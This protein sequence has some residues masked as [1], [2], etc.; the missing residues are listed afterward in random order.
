MLKSLKT[1]RCREKNCFCPFVAL[2]YVKMRSKMRELFGK[3]P[4]LR[5]CLIKIRKILYH[6]IKSALLI[7]KYIYIFSK[8][9]SFN[10]CSIIYSIVTEK[11]I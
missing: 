8:Y 7:Y 11:N 1:N 10:L 2:F 4:M 3:Y 9:E 5:F 6:K